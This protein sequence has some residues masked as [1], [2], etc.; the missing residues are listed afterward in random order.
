M[1]FTNLNKS[2]TGLFRGSQL[3]KPTFVFGTRLYRQPTNLF[4]TAISNPEEPF[5]PNQYYEKVVRLVLENSLHDTSYFARRARAL[6]VKFDSF[7]QAGLTA[8]KALAAL[9]DKYAVLMD[10]HNLAELET[11][12]ESKN[13][14]HLY[15]MEENERI[16]DLT[17]SSFMSWHV[18]EEARGCLERAAD[19]ESLI[20]D[21]RA[22]KGGLLSEAFKVFELLSDGG[23]FLNLDGRAQQRFW[24]TDSEMHTL[25]LDGSVTTNQRIG[26]LTGGKPLVVLVNEWTA[27]AA[28]T[29]VRALEKYRGAKIVGM[30]TYGKAVAQR[31]WL[32]DGGTCLRL[33][34]A[35]TE[36][37]GVSTAGKQVIRP[38]Y[39]IPRLVRCDAQ[40]NLAQLICNG[41][42]AA[43]E[44]MDGTSESKDCIAAVYHLHFLLVRD[45]IAREVNLKDA[46]VRFENGIQSIRELHGLGIEHEG[47][48]FRSG[49][50]INIFDG[51]SDQR[52][53]ITISFA[54]LF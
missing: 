50:K 17:I 37:N 6:E 36:L 38:H 27:S 40:Y 48:L 39:Q 2:I 18:A 34:F 14:C 30:P 52:C 42:I 5:T 4:H 20:I 15:T 53:G 24:L 45:L 31:Y 47:E 32:L 33:T 12:L 46:S 7:E 11:S 23:E 26:N 9:G 21:L 41:M 19:C 8:R 44:Y 25:E 51:D 43:E 29:M 16:C 10:A 3:N 22:N 54:P 49:S 13:Q 28:E 35:G 1:V